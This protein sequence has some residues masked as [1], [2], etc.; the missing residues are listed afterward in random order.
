[1]VASGSQLAER[2]GQLAVPAPARWRVS[3]LLLDTRRQRIWRDSHEIPLPKLTYDL[4]VAL[5]RCHPTVISDG[6]LMRT[7]WPGLVVSQET[8]SQR[9]KLLRDAL[10]DDSRQPRYIA[11]LRSR[12]YYLVGT[13]EALPDVDEPQLTVEPAQVGAQTEDPMTSAEDPL[14]STGELALL[15]PEWCPAARDRPEWAVTQVIPLDIVSGI[16]PNLAELAAPDADAPCEGAL[17]VPARAAP[18]TALGEPS[19]APN[20]TTPRR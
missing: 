2:A 15:E 14:T 6:E 18:A 13:V 1:M 5:V 20:G 17:D 4:F 16:F 8:I 7:V 10:G 3:D 19:S 11:R 12:G 9:V